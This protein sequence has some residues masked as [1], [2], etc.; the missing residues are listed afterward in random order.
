M[1]LQNDIRFWLRCLCKDINSM[2]VPLASVHKLQVQNDNRLT[3]L[4]NFIDS[5]CET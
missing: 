3:C 4:C 1:Q 2:G 5:E